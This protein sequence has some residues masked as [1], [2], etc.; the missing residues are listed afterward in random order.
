MFKRNALILTVL[1]VLLVSFAL[2]AFLIKKDKYVFHK[3]VTTKKILVKNLLGINGFEWDV[4]QDPN[5]PA[6]GSRVY[7]PKFDLLKSF[8]LFRHYIDWEKLEDK[9]GNYSF[10]PTWRGSWNYDV[11]Y[12]RFKQE[13]TL[14]LACI[15]NSPDWLHKTYPADEQDAENLPLTYGSERGAPKSYLAMA[16]VAF[17]FAARYGSN[18]NVAPS[19]LSVN[20]TLRWNGDTPN[21]VK[22]GLNTVKYIECN[23]EPDKWWK[24]KKA[25]QTASEYAANLSAF[26]DGHM[27]K[28]GANAGV[29]NA[30][31]NMV[32]VMA[33]LAA[34]D[35]AY[36]S[37]IVEWCRKNRGYKKNGDI[38]LCFDVV[39]YHLY[40]NNNEDLIQK[41][42]KDK[43]GVAP[44]LSKQ[45]KIADD[46]IAVTKKIA[47]NMEVWVT[48]AGYDVHESSPQKAIAIGE[49]SE[50]ITQADWMVRSSLLFARHGIDK[51]FYYIL[52]DVNFTG[53]LYGSSGFVVDGRKRPVA[54][55]FY[56]LKNLMGNYQY[57]QT[58]NTDPLVDVYML[59]DKKMFALCIPDE[60]GR[61]QLYKLALKGHQKAIIYYLKAGTDKMEEKTV[62]VINGFLTVNVTETPMFI[63]GI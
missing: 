4:L 24:G 8:G 55:Y 25:E 5:E 22:V 44:E 19:L 39:N 36:V 63:Q 29:K 1:I 3:E 21:E 51:V 20:S 49:K 32:V 37:Q 16:K 48:E 52:N 17:Q 27:G 9:P 15:K 54:D 46:F 41:L 6:V 57:L 56:Q 13:G 43:R 35:T 45:G 31:P 18:K 33:G 40:A 11:V 58:L 47:K 23:N 12:E 59:G 34:P 28:L 61:T 14:V 38:N 30:D 2:F 62:N 50:L 10:N 7:E 60:V 42:L 26:Y 53:G